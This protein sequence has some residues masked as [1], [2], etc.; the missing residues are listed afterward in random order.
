MFARS[1]EAQALTTLVR[2][3]PRAPWTVDAQG[4]KDG[5]PSGKL[6]LHKGPRPAH[7]RRAAAVPTPL[8]L[9][10]Q[11][12]DH[13]LFHPHRWPCRHDHHSSPQVVAAIPG[14]ALS[15]TDQ[16][17]GDARFCYSH[18]T[19][20][21]GGGPAGR[22]CAAGAEGWRLAG[23]GRVAHHQR[24][25]REAGCGRLGDTTASP[26]GWS[27]AAVPAAQARPVCRLGQ[28]RVQAHHVAVQGAHRGH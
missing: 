16:W 11:T 15:N 13:Y 9:T 26:G 21:T 6:S 5:H 2:R 18:P 10:I 25:H 1:A 28:V 22:L 12:H 3:L 23:C 7:A 19:A 8:L 4:Y 20:V 14:A 24:P 27:T 17:P